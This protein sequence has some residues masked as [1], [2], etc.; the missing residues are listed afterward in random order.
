MSDKERYTEN[1]SVRLTKTQRN[2]LDKL[3]ATIRDAVEFYIDR[4][5][6][7]RLKLLDRKR[8]LE[9]VIKNKEFEL[10]QLKDELLQI[11]ADLGTTKELEQTLS[12]D[13]I[14]DGNK[15]IENYRKWNINGND[16]IDNY[17]SVNKQCK[18]AIKHFISEHGADNKDKYEKQLIEYI[19][20]NCD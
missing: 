7:P 3:D 9:E 10:N 17:L 8:E 12:L 4:Q 16:T 18:R 2:K 11:N 5:T 13:V 14:I 19:K 1:M 15:I 6:N 20:D